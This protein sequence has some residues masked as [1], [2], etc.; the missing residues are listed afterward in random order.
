MPG[1]AP[2]QGLITSLVSTFRSFLR[3]GPRQ[4]ACGLGRSADDRR[5]AWT[6]F[7][8]VAGAKAPAALDAGG[9]WRASGGRLLQPVNDK[10]GR[11][12]NAF[13]HEP[14]HGYRSIDGGQTNQADVGRVEMRH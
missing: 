2:K 4:A 12:R 11:Q 9:S 3:E 14:T 10:A 6:P 1:R 7:E 8:S 5:G 13:R